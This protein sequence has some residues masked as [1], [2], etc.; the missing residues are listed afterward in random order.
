MT[1][2]CFC[3][4]Y[5]PPHNCNS[6]QFCSEQSEVIGAVQPAEEQGRGDLIAASQYLEGTYK[7]AG[8]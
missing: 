3:T 6:V 2:I 4:S 7:K 5:I 1:K 8:E